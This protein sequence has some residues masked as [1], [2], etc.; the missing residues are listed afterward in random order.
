M[1]IHFKMLLKFWSFLDLKL[2]YQCLLKSMSTLHICVHVV[3]T[4]E[5][6]AVKKLFSH[7]KQ[8]KSTKRLPT[9]SLADWSN[10]KH[11]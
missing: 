8:L 11:I 5:F 10:S 6:I 2:T 1:Q 3:R 9:V 4:V 7:S